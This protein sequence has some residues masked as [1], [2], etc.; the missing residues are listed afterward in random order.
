MKLIAS[1]LPVFMLALTPVIT[2]LS[3]C[4][5]ISATASP[6]IIEKKALFEDEVQAKRFSVAKGPLNWL[7]TNAP[8][9]STGLYIKGAETFDALAQAEKNPAKKQGYIDSL[10]IIYDLRI[11]TCGEEANV[12]NRK[13]MS[14]YKYYY[15]SKDKSKE[16]LPLMDKA[17]G[18]SNEKIL[19]GLAETY[20][21]A[22][23]ISADQKLLDENQILT[24]YEKITSI[25]DS[26]IKKAEAEQKPVDRYKK[27]NEDNLT[28]LMYLVK[29]NCDFVR[30][31][32]GPQ[33]KQNPSDL[34]LAKKIFNFMLKDK[35][36]DDPLWLQAAETLH[37][38]EKDFGLAK[39]LALRYL[40]NKEYDKAAPMLEEAL[41]LAKQPS[42]K[43]EILGLQAQQQEMAGKHDNARQL[44]LKAVA[45]DPSKKEYY[46]RIGDIY[47][48]SFSECKQEKHQ[49]E[50]RFVFLIAYDMYQKAGETQKMA[51]AKSSFPSMEE[52]F[53][54]DYKRGDKVKVACWINEETIIRTRN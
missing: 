38:A 31:K 11:K 36:T 5:D 7:L 35:C 2:A 16:I 45:A 30:K 1:L 49:A 23:K 39:I 42:D 22:V 12:T 52:I 54:L 21:S 41:Q 29:I 20:M 24:R 3:Q 50:D 44:Y 13:A 32:F 34:E 8:N 17:I 37:A 33:F 46:A 25:I 15:D 48:N 19:D 27:M 18:L 43:A 10:M 26:K 4:K 51:N 40:S 53:E 9:L 6:A 47:M 28:I 14:F